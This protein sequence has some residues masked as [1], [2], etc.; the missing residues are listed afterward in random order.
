MC[1]ASLANSTHLDASFSLPKN[2]MRFSL[3]VGNVPY[4][5]GDD[6]QAKAALKAWRY[7]LGT[8]MVAADK[9]RS[10]EQPIIY[11]RSV[12]ASSFLSVPSQKRTAPAATKEISLH[13]S[14]PLVRAEPL[15]QRDSELRLNDLCLLQVIPNK[16]SACPYK[17]PLTRPKQENTLTLGL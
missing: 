17:A 5:Q 1:V 3:L 4:V 7:C 12:P 14:L 16:Q 8:V 10:L 6:R 15:S 13:C 2:R 11:R 9:T